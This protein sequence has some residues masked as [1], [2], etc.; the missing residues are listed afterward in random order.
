MKTL[1]YLNPA[2]QQTDREGDTEL[3]RIEGA[4]SKDAVECM[5]PGQ[6]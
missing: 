1:E 4:D 5:A 2:I 6:L 3:R